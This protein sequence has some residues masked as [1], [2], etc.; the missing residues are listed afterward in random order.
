MDQATSILSDSGLEKISELLN[1]KTY[2]SN[3]KCKTLIK[4]KAYFPNIKETIF[5][6]SIITKFRNISNDDVSKMDQYFDDF[7]KC[8]E[9]C[10]FFFEEQNSLESLEE[11]TFGQLIFQQDFLK[12][13][14]HIP[15]FIM[16]ISYMKI[17][18][19]PLVSVVFPLFAYFLPYLLIKYVWRLPISYEMYQ[20]IMGKMW[21]F[22]FD[23]SSEKILQ[24]IVTLF[25]IGQSIYQPIQNAMH[26]YT[27]HS[28]IEN[29]GK[30]I[31]KYNETIEKIKKLLQQYNITF[32]ISNGLSNLPSYNDNHRAFI[33]LLEQPQRLW[34]TSK[35]VST[36]EILWKISQ[37][38]DFNKVNLYS[39]DVPYFT[40][41]NIV[42]IHLTKEDRVGSTL[43]IKE[44]NNH[45][46]LSGPNG[47][48]K[49]SFLRGMLQTI[50]FGQTF[51]YSIA[52]DVHMTP[53][54][55][56]LSGLHIQDNPGRESLFEK[57]VIFAR[58]VLYHNNPKYK[59]FILFDEIFHSTNPPDGIRTSK[60][61]LNKL[62]S[63]NH[64]CSI[65]STHV[66]EIIE[67]SPDTIQKICVNAVSKN[68]DLKYDYC[69]SKGICKESS[70]EKIWKKQWNAGS[71]K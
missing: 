45:F 3:E 68:G 64:I 16:I 70:V 2:Y 26:L 29:L 25:T 50:L 13:L 6:Q 49:S 33:E 41:T 12:T 37:N 66:F 34:F 11:D 4:K 71:K 19:V 18:F 63:Y 42:D 61:F 47:G 31:Y 55:Y 17:F 21:S 28:N 69:I 60:I 36:L 51:G 39:M 20:Q 52:K 27:I 54:D 67:T 22:S 48:G 53:F 59:G 32:Y 38:E 24:N 30:S 44:K 46:L 5:Y 40:A 35:D 43:T 57:E 7:V 10:K 15:F 14:N 1:T 23:M 56:I 65:I 58:D 8:E 62:W 9:E